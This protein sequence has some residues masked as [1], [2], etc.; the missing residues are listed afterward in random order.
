MGGVLPKATS[1]QVR[2]LV[3]ERKAIL[4]ENSWAVIRGP[5]VAAVIAPTRTD[6]R[7][8]SI[9]L[10]R[11][12]PHYRCGRSIQAYEQIQEMSWP[13]GALCVVEYNQLGLQ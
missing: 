12:V 7:R 9:R 4:L 10:N 11:A 1:S 2:V 3:N 13:A 6:A 8:C 5:G